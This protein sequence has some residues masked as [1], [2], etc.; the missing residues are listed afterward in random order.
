MLSYWS[1]KAL[2]GQFKFNGC[3]LNQRKYEIGF[4]NDYQNKIILILLCN[5]FISIAY[6]IWF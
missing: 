4:A 6:G 2:L 1:T 5:T 3:L